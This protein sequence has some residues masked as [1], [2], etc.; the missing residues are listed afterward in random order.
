MT[1]WFIYN[2]KENFEKLSKYESLT[3][4]QK[5][6]LANRD[7]IEDGQVEAIIDSSI[8]NFYDPFLLK[9]MQ[10]GVDLLFEH[11]SKGSKVRI[12]GDY[13]ADGVS[14]TTILM[15]G[16]GLF[17]DE[18]SYV[19]PDRLEDGYGLNEAIVDKAL[20]DGVSLLITCD[21]GIAAFNAIDYAMDHA[22]DVIVTDHHQVIFDNGE[23]KIP[24][25]SAVINPSQKSCNY[26][27]KTICG[28]VVA[29]KFVDTFQKKYG[30]DLGV[31]KEYVEQLLQFA[32]IGTITDVMDLVDENRIIVIEG[33]KLL[34]DSNNLGVIELLKQLNW[35]KEITVY[36]VGFIIGPTINA[37]GRLFTAKLAVELFLDDDISTIREYA[38]EL[39]SLN[40]E[41]KELTKEAVESALELMKST[42]LKD[43]DI[44]FL[45]MKEVHESICGLVAGRIKEQYHKPVLVFTDASDTDKHLIK[46]SGRSIE[47]YDMHKKLS[48]FSE[49]FEAFGGHKMA[50]GMTLEYDKYHKV[51]DIANRDSGLKEE[52]FK[53]K[54][55]I[56]TAL[57][58]KQISFDLINQVTFLEPFGKGFEKPKFASKSVIIDNIAILGK[59]RNVLKMT[60]SQNGISIDAITFNVTKHL[61]Y[62]QA[63]FNI[64]D[65][66]RNLDKLLGRSIDIVYNL[67]INSFRDRETIQL[68]IEEMR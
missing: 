52:D 60:L 45:Y 6:I 2:K 27:F 22:I 40:Q 19:I 51:K 44:I 39:I 50:C 38:R 3:S 46:G 17:Y 37:T 5:L 10:Q 34:N 1:N 18:L 30:N 55:N 53:K 67:Q 14:S 15:K 68:M 21:N 66:E 36:T 59:D 26:P 32:A 33:L 48:E 42:D 62:L 64:K 58:F 31:S 28:A 13:D 8:D 24:N 57:D 12:V 63:K 4:L 9:D 7:I 25:A 35:D 20:E 23:E 43:D 41:R 16:L 11:M 49:Y 47:A 65:I 54:I 61:Q 56:D 29:Y